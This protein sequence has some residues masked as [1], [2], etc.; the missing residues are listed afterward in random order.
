MPSQSP[1]LAMHPVD[2]AVTHVLELAR[3]SAKFCKQAV[4]EDRVADAKLPVTVQVLHPFFRTLHYLH[5]LSEV[6]AYPGLQ[7]VQPVKVG[8]VAKFPVTVHTSQLASRE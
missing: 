8:G 7:A 2:C 4:H 3:S 1:A 5:L 6:L